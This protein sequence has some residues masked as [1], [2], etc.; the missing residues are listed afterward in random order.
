MTNLKQKI[1]KDFDKR[2][3]YEEPN[4]ALH[5][6]LSQA[7]DRV[8]LKLLEEIK[9]EFENPESERF[10]DT[11]SFERGKSVGK[12]ELRHEL[13]SKISEL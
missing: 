8:Q 2:F 3:P 10:G 5:D 6:F 4:Y 1:L 12:N 11:Y 7:I 13:L 9:K